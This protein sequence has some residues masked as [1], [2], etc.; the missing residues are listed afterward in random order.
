MS[1]S[2]SWQRSTRILHR[3][4]YVTLIALPSIAQSSGIAVQSTASIGAADP[5]KS[6]IDPAKIAEVRPVEEVGAFSSYDRTG[7]NDDGFSGKYSCLRREG[8]ACVIAETNGPGAI[9]RMFLPEPFPQGPIE[10]YFD[11]EKTPRIAGTVPELF[12]GQHPPFKLPLAGHKGG[13]TFSYVPI[14]FR[15]SIKVVVRTPVMHFYMVNYVRFKPGTI[16]SSFNPHT[17]IDYPYPK[18]EGEVIR[19]NGELA[20]GGS[21][22]L[23]DRQKPGRIESIRIGPIA[24]L[25]DSTRR[26][27]LRMYWDGADDPA[28]NVPVGDF[29]GFSFGKPSARSLLMGSD[30]KAGYL[31]LPMPFDRTARVELVSED[32]TASPLPITAEVT[33]SDLPRTSDE[34]YFHALWRR[35]NPTTIGKDYTYV[36]VSGRGQLVGVVLQAQ[37]FEPGETPFFEGNEIAYIDG[38]MALQGDGSESSFNGCWYDV[39]GRWYGAF[40][41]PF[42]GSLGYNKPIARTGG[43]RLM[44]P[45]A[46]S[47]QKHLLY[48]IQHA[49][50]GDN[51][52]TDYT[53]TAYYYLDRPTGE[54]NSLPVASARAVSPPREFVLKFWPSPPP[55]ESVLEASLLFKSAKFGTD[56][57]FYMELNRTLTQDEGKGPVEFTEGFGA[58]HIAFNLTP[59]QSGQYE[60]FVDGFTSQD[61]AMVQLRVDDDVVGKPV[62]FY[63]MD[64][65]RTG[66]VSLGKVHLTDG[67]NTLFVLMPARNPKST[68]TRLRI[69]SIKGKL[70]Q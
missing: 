4:L 8:D 69:I 18:I 30:D 28:V 67:I 37:G 55:I 62:D 21:M 56:L 53:S 36:D 35:E 64:G 60:I 3:Y 11:G 34:L 59:P 10:F 49:P 32:P 1:R 9:T 27:I 14:A 2:E 17:L 16:V 70:K 58:P 39:P 48:T 26:R 57:L 42:S 61:S 15:N 6:L 38:K 22:T 23:L 40:S 33:V 41:E 20:G 43:F 5:I 29:F 52:L 31:T 47:F 25:Q 7:N 51:L 44:I 50:V 19:T 65:R 66:P 54:D 13:G 24:S 68:G 45:D 63:G 46:Y 12:H